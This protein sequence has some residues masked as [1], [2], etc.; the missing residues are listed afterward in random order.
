MIIIIDAEKTII[1]L[2][3][4]TLW[5]YLVSKEKKKENQINRKLF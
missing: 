3:V 2:F 4:V 1:A 5:C